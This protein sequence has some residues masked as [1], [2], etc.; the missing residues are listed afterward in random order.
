MT[1][2]QVD[3]RN[4]AELL[5]WEAQRYLKDIELDF[6]MQFAQNRR[7]CVDT[8]KQLS[9]YLAADDEQGIEQFSA[10]LQ[11]ALVKLKRDVWAYLVEWYDDEDDL[12]GGSPILNPRRPNPTPHNND[13]ADLPIDDPF[14]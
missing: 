9:E 12:T 2:E 11:S 5:I 4:S 1:Q 8:I 7:Q 14:L 13:S 10:N 6:E 3:K